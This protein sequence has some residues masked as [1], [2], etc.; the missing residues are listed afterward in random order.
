MRGSDSHAQP[1]TYTFAH[2]QPF[3]HHDPDA[4]R[5]ARGANANTDR[6]AASGRERDLGRRQLLG[7]GESS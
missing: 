6:H 5:H 1:Y 3:T 7:R 4:D 2:A